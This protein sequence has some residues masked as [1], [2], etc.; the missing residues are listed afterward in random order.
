MTDTFDPLDF[1]DLLGH[2]RD[3]TLTDTQWA[4]LERLIRTDPTLRQRYLDEI[5]LRGLLR[6]RFAV[7]GGAAVPNFSLP[8]PSTPA[9]PSLPAAAPASARRRFWQ[10]PRQRAAGQRIRVWE[11][12]G[13]L[14]A[15]VILTCLLTSPIWLPRLRE[16][17]PSAATLLSA[18]NAQWALWGPAPQVD[19]LLPT[20]LLN[21]KSGIIDI[22]YANGTDLVIESPARFSVDS[23]NSVQLP[24]GKLS[25][26][27]PHSTAGFTVQTPTGTIRDLGTE[28]GVAVAADQSTYTEV[29][30]GSVAVSA[31]QASAAPRIVHV[32]E[33]VETRPQTTEVRTVALRPQ[34]FVRQVPRNG[35][36]LAAGTPAYRRWQA[37]SARLR[38]DPALVAYYTFDKPARGRLDL[39]KNQA[40][41]TAGQSDGRID[42][43]TWDAGRFAGKPALHFNGVD[44]RVQVNI[45][46]PL[47]NL[48][49]AV[50]LYLDVK[51]HN[52]TAILNSDGWNRYGCLHFQFDDQGELRC[53]S[54]E[55]G[56]PNGLA[57]PHSTA[58]G[59]PGRWEFIA[60]AYDR[61]TGM[62]QAYRDGAPL[63]T[64]HVKWCNPLVIGAAEIGHWNPKGL[65]CPYPDRHLHGRIDELAVFSRVLGAAEIAR[66]YAAG[67]PQ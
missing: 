61:K 46:A 59:L 6:A 23:P 53:D 52:M 20:G 35:A 15:V 56:D 45:P 43:A 1:S 4:Q 44:S 12:V 48:T 54:Y 17:P 22:Q 36:V 26:Q 27:V 39:L 21:L 2:L 33:A 50:W 10:L 42:G 63:Y 49:V 16:R 34:N 66:M 8:T 7:P 3:E 37:Y 5:M 11:V 32:A 51:D 40:T 28:F 19:A 14:A 9:T 58:T 29:F 65:M 60:C 24:L 30:K 47:T 38:Q 57:H 67:K 55:A 31:A 25:A 41:A 18:S 13:S 62:I 64:E